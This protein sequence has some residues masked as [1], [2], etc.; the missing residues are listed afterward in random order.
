MN[1]L[2]KTVG[3]QLKVYRAK[4]G[5]R[6]QAAL[7]EA[8]GVSEAAIAT[9]EAGNAAPLLETTVKLA[10]ALG[11]TPNDLCGFGAE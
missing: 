3:H 7:A 11:C 2:K 8:S 5:M 4:A 1:D 10:E 6:S 9:Y